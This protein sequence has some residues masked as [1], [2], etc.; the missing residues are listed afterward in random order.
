MNTEL[1]IL[2]ALGRAL[3]PLR[4]A[5]RAGNLV[6]DFYARKPRAK[7][8]ATVRGA[9]FELDPSENVD[10][11]LLFFPQLYDRRELNR[12]LDRLAP[13]DVFVD[14]GAHIGLYAIL[15]AS[16]VAPGGRSIA[17]EADP[18]NHAR[19]RANV[20]LNPGL[21][22]DSTCV[23]ISDRDETARLSL[24]TSGNRGGNSLL[25]EGPEG[26]TI[27][28]LP[29][30]KALADL[31]VERVDAMK[32]DVEGMEY[33]ILKRFL[34]DAP[35]RSWPHTIVMEFQ[36]SWTGIAGGSSL[37]LLIAS[38]YREVVRTRENR[39]LERG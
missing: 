28:C 12:L 33:R 25:G 15:A 24:N 19:L 2:R 17:F 30:R 37:D 9:T 21:G 13:G 34:D 10:G 26:A 39:V 29:L 5:G 31:G 32:L 35:E 27:R 18:V 3:P 6:R 14:V 16:R 38:G 36:P 4:G 23:G 7:V 20:A 11:S 1:R 22:V 8:T